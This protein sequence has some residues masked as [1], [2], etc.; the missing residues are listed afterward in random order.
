MADA[1][2]RNQGLI[3][4]AWGGSRPRGWRELLSLDVLPGGLAW[5][6]IC[7]HSRSR[8]ITIT[9][10]LLTK[11]CLFNINSLCPP[12]QPE[13]VPGSAE[14]R[15]CNLKSC[16]QTSADVRWGEDQSLTAESPSLWLHL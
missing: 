10:F 7:L 4:L 2:R 15:R 3:D 12:R 8:A 11:W 13:K 6:G 9:T 16:W 5:E 1:E 14:F